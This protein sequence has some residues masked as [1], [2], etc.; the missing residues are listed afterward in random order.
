LDVFY[1]DSQKADIL[2]RLHYDGTMPSSPTPW[3]LQNV[4]RDNVVLPLWP[5]VV[6]SWADN[7]LDIFQKYLIGQVGLRSMR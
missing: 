6:S 4:G 3:T 5:V 2:W 7:T 1:Y